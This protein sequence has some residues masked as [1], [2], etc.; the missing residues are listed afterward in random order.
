M[1]VESILDATGGI[2]SL[3]E[4]E[5]A[6][7]CRHIRLPEP[8][9]QQILRTPGGT[10][11]LDTVWLRWG[12][13]TEIHGIPHH[14]ITRW[15]E[16]LMRLNDISIEGAGLLVFSSYATRHLAVRVGRQLVRMFQSRGWRPT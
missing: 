7:I 2:Q 10:F 12:V 14:N 3:P 16:D 4:R 8:D 5:F 9:R 11:Y 6:L 15:D 1:I 13:R